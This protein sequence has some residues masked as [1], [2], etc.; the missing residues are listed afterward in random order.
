MSRYSPIELAEAFIRTG[1]LADA[2]DALNPHLEANPTDGTAL[3]LRAAVL[4]RLPGEDYARA[5]L[6]DL[7]KLDSKNADDYVQESVIWQL[8]FGDW[9]QALKSTEQ[10]HNLAP[11]DERITERLLMLYDHEGELDKAQALI[12][13]LPQTWRWLQLAGDVA[14]KAHQSV[15]AIEHYSQAITL[16]KQKMDTENNP[17]AQN[18][19][20]MLVGSR[21][22]AQLEAG[23]LPAAEADYHAAA[24]TFPT[25]LSYS[26]LVGVTLALQNK[27]DEAVLLCRSV[28]EDEP[29]LEIMLREKAAAYPGLKPLLERLG[30]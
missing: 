10:A 2:L 24:D 8:G 28:L 12:E 13:T 22:A 18:I 1:E 7:N 14:H 3:R 17:I 29:T 16:L 9:S 5:A 15:L 19:M 6:A 27:V 20:G 26:L 11:N 30:L 4:M 21:A 25:D 23:R